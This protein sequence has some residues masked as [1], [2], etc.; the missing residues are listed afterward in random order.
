MT[1]MDQDMMQKNITCKSLGDAQKNVGLFSI[2]LIFANLLF[3]I[4]GAMLYVFALEKGIELPGKTDELYPT[5]ALQYLPTSISL[6]FV[7]GLIAAAYSSADSAL[8]S[9]TTSFCVDFLGFESSSKGEKEKRTTRIIVHIGFSIILLLVI[10]LVKAL[11]NDAIVNHLFRAAGYTYGPI[12]GLFLFAILTKRQWKIKISN[13]KMNDLFVPFVA[14]VAI[15][16]TVILDL[17]SKT[18]FG[19]FT[20]GNV[21]MVVNASFMFMGL[22]FFS[23]K[24]T[25]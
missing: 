1:G 12:M 8:T 14:I 13:V 25:E 6:L 4:L 2:I 15:G 5:L 18:W 23:K 16:I 3:L 17:N 11:P 22:Y 9:L 7:L 19:G 20:F 10:L 24:T 21:I